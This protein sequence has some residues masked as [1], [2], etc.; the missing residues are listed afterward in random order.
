MKSKFLVLTNTV[1]LGAIELCMIATYPITVQAQ[2][3]IDRQHGME[4]VI[5]G[6]SVSLPWRTNGKKLELS[7]TGL[8]YQFGLELLNT[9]NYRQQPVDGYAN[10]AMNLVANLDQQYRYLDITKLAVMNKWRWQVAGN[11]LQI[12]TPKLLVSDVQASNLGSERGQIN[13]KLDGTVPWRLSQDATEG[14]LTI[15]TAAKPQLIQPSRATSSPTPSGNEPGDDQKITNTNF[16]VTSTGQKTVIQFPIKLGTRARAKNMA[17]RQIAIDITPLAMTE[18]KI[19]WA[20]GLVWQQQWQKLGKDHFPVSTL[21]LDPRQVRLRPMLSQ[22]DSVIG[23]NPIGKIATD[24]H[25]AAAINGGYF[26][27]NTRQPLG[28][29]KVNGQWL[30]SPILGRSGL[31]W[32]EKGGWQIARL[33]YAENISSGQGQKVTNGFL[34][35]GYTQNGVAR[36][37]TAWGK[38]YQTITNNELV[39]TIQNN[40]IMQITPRAAAGS[41]AIPIPTNG[42]LLVGRGMGTL[43]DW[44]LGSKVSIASASNPAT[45]DRYAHVMGAGPW[46]IQN[47]QVVLDAPAEKFSG[48]F[49]TQ[50]AAR[51]AIAMNSQ[52]KILI[53]AIHDRSGGK[54]PTL[55]ELAQLLKQMGAVDALNL[56]GGSSTSMVLGGQMINRS[57]ATAARVHNGLGIFLG[58]GSSAAE[59]R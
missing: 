37:T 23:S 28:A 6:S 16:Q 57:P 20:P 59:N 24:Q 49:G 10:V 7:D 12:N 31:G 35:S 34:N 4:I 22:S 30:S 13:I 40:R 14:F 52:G 42:Y 32:Q 5:N 39:L 38:V 33:A 55:G 1:F 45:F 15:Y 50:S 48:S 18:R 9:S 46:L 19:A 2:N 54:G 29:L 56:D 3:A 53:V 11:R 41:A 58:S 25:A 44:P 26:N 8:L 51:S 47:R 27:R 36:Y 17:G 43:D 21:E